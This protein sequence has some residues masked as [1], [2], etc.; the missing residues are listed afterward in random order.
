[1]LIE[2]CNQVSA[3]DFRKELDK[4]VA[5][6]RKGGGP[7]AITQDSEVVGFFIAADEYEAMFGAAVK[8][9]L[10]ARARGPTVTH[11]EARARLRKVS[12]P[13]SRKP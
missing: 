12:R 4:Y 3:E 5:A 1:M 7:I 10:S 2:T 13:N 8:K 9:L 11:E 6:A